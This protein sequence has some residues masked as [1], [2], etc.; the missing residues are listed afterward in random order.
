MTTKDWG[1]RLWYVLHLITFNYPE[2]PSFID[3]QHYET[4]FLSL[5]NVLPCSICREHYKKI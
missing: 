3:K 1:P 2:N 5:Q 4:F